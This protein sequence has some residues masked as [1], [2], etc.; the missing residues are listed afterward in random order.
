[1]S[2]KTQH[3]PRHLSM[4]RR[5]RW[6]HR[7]HVIQPIVG[8]YCGAIVYDTMKLDDHSFWNLI[9]KLVELIP[10]EKQKQLRQELEQ[11]EKKR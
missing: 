7:I 8:P 11:I 2:K 1:M 10:P 5:E 6:S 9:N 3:D 4:T